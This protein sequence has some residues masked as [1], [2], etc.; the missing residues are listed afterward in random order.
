[1]QIWLLA[2]AVTRHLAQTLAVRAQAATVQTAMVLGIS[3]ARMGMMLEINLARMGMATV[4]IVRTTLVGGE[5]ID[6]EA[7]EEE[8]LTLPLTLAI[9]VPLTTSYHGPNKHV[10]VA[11]RGDKVQ[12]QP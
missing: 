1:M 11:Y 2:E 4:T 9:A 5:F 6:V 3:L 10:T 12:S 8:T 7:E